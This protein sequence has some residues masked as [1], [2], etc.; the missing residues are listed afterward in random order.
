[1]IRVS[2][3]KITIQNR[4]D[5]I[6]K[7]MRRIQRTLIYGTNKKKIRTKTGKD[8]SRKNNRKAKIFE[9]TSAWRTK[10]D[11][12]H[13]GPNLNNH[14]AQMKL[15]R[16]KITKWKAKTTLTKKAIKMKAIK[17][18]VNRISMNSSQI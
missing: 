1:M 14:N 17:T 16:N 18:K 2:Q 15:C 7:E 12:S 3:Q 13:M 4:K 9:E 6:H 11:I 10:D 5:A 8:S